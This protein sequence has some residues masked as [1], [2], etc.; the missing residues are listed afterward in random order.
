M[1]KHLKTMMFVG[2]AIA[3]FVAGVS[4]SSLAGATSGDPSRAQAASPA[5]HTLPGEDVV[6]RV[7]GVPITETELKLKLENDSHEAA[8]AAERRSA[9]LQSLIQ[10]EVLAQKARAE[11]LDRDPKYLAMRRVKEAQMGSFERQELSE[12]LLA[13]EGERRSA[14][15]E[16]S[17]RAFFR[18]NEQRIRTRVH[19]LMILR[20]SEAAIIEARSAIDRGKPF[21]EVAESLLPGGLPEGKKP[22]DLGYLSFQQ[23]PGPWRETV[24]DLKP[25]EMSGVL[26][27]PNERFWLVKLVDTREDA[28]VT[29]ES[30]RAAIESDM[31]V[32]RVQRTRDDLQ[33]ELLKGARIEMLKPAP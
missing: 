1:K 29:F 24:Y 9:V 2:G 21:E 8:P 10:R 15:T 14:P 23:V 5:T 30:A 18:A 16:E 13:R 19:V 32:N 28:D 31:A 12:L 7:N 11:G 25:G 27:G 3:C 22:W 33:K 26:R 6:A 17:A 4:A 20:R